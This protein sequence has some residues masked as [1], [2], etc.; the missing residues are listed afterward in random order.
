M[1]GNSSEAEQLEVSQEE[2]FSMELDS[3]LLLYSL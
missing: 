1:L 2:L 3:T